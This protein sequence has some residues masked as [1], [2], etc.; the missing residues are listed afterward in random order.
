MTFGCRGILEAFYGRPWSWEERH[1][2][3]DFMHEEGLGAYLYAPKNDPIH[4]NRWQEPYTDE[5]WMQ[6]QR[7]NGHARDL[8]IELIFGLSALAFR[9][10]EKAHLGV[11]QGKIRAAR[12]RGL[13]SFALLLDDLPD[14]FEHGDDRQRFPDLAHAQAWLV[15]ELFQEVAPDGQ[16][17]FCPTEYH[18]PGTSDYLR[19]LGARLPARAQVFWTGSQICSPRLTEEELRRVSDVLQRPVVVWDNFP[20]ND[21]DMQ[22]DLHVA[23]LRHRAPGLA[24]AA[25]GYFAAA[26]PRVSTSQLALRTTAAYLRN[27]HGYQP[28]PEFM[29]AVRRATSSE[30]EA[31][32]VAFLADLAR[33]H[34]LTDRNEV[35]HHA[36]WPD[37]DAFWAARGGSGKR[38]GPELPGRPVPTPV[39]PDEAPLRSAVQEM[40]RHAFTLAHLHDPALRRD[41][42]PWT[43]KLAGWARVMKYALGALDHPHDARTREYVLE[44]LALVRENFHWVAG[45]TFDHFARRCLRAAGETEELA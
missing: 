43:A 45:D 17:Y 2:M 11:L 1:T 18:G 21:L 24:R 30:S 23:P 40:E 15:N 37:I 19:T 10:T 4:R 35:L 5:E 6:F 31:A 8:G 42:A 26:G 27:P 44:E 9:Y 12:Q 36:L 14:R 33:R 7:L 39:T 41:L 28:E 29:K 34:P 25:A 13:R 20:V 32:A 22:Y 38:A 16:F 3:L